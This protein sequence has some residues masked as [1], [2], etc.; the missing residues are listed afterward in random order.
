M[1]RRFDRSFAHPPSFLETVADKLAYANDTNCRIECSNHESA[2][3]KREP[4]L[5]NVFHEN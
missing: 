2:I 5:K 3:G 1:V 4:T